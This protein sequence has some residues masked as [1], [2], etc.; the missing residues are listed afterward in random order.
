MIEIP[1]DLKL[2]TT[3][4]RILEQLDPFYLKVEEDQRN[5]E[6]LQEYEIPL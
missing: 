5:K 6:E 3:F 1:N 2:E 4:V